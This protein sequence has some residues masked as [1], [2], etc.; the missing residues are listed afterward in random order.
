ME[1]KLIHIVRQTIIGEL[2]FWQQLAVL[3]Q[4]FNITL[5]KGIALIAA[6]KTDLCLVM[7]LI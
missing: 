1:I 4:S 6:Q 7:H 3:I 2:R 5:D